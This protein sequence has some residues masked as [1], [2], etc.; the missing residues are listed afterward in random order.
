MLRRAE[1]AFFSAS[2]APALLAATIGEA[3]ARTI[4]QADVAVRARST[5]AAAPIVATLHALT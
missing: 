2:V 3:K 1:P 5:L 4:S